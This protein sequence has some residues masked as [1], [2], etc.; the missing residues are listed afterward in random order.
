MTKASIMS[1][2]NVIVLCYNVTPSSVVSLLGGLVEIRFHT[3]ALN[4]KNSRKNSINGCKRDV[5][6]RTFH[7][8]K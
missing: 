3:F 8:K 6:T 7:V 1:Q 2:S 4:V 5:Y